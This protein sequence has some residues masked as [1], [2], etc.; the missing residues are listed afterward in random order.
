[1]P[2]VIVG[3]YYLDIVPDRA[4]LARYGLMIGDVQEVIAT[5][6]G[7]ET[8]TTT[9]EGRERYGVNIRYPREF[10]SIG[11]RSRRG[12]GPPAEWRHGSAR[13]G[14]EV[15]LA[16]GPTR[17]APR[18][19]SLPVYVFVDVRDRDLGS[20]VAEA[21]KAVAQ[22]RLNSRRRLCDLERPV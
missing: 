10:R 15:D 13:R 1:M 5:A 12:V 7:G 11:R 3:G 20:Y 16:R 2:S 14:R 9:V 21:R 19:A 17:F 4:A 22:S 6:L 8:V 18:T